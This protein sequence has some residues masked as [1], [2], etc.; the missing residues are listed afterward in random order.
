MSLLRNVVCIKWGSKYSAEYVNKL[1]S[2]V[3]RNLSLPHRFICLTDDSTGLSSEIETKSLL[4]KELKWSY[5]KFELF[6]KKLQDIIGQILFLDLDVVINNSIDDLFLFEP[7]AEFVGIKDWK[8]D[9]I[10]AS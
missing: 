10:N 2:M 7:D 1:H 5:T 4:R 8:I 9:C 3:E 6:E